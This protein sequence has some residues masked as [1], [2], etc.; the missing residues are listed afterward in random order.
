MHA[1]LHHG[2][3]VRGHVYEAA[4]GMLWGE[5]PRGPAALTI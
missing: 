5:P 4:A 1:G 2:I 3:V